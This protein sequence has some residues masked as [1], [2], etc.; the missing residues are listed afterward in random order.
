MPDDFV[1]SYDTRPVRVG[2]L[3]RQCGG[4]EVWRVRDIRYDE[5][6]RA[7]LSLVHPHDPHR[8]SALY[9]DRVV[10]VDEES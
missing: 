2:T 9:V 7:S 5:T 4:G 8:Y 3:V 1:L 6:G 10:V